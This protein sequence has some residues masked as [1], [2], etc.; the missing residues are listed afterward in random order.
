MKTQNNKL[1]FTK[2]S[3]IELNDQE[4]FDID[5][6]AATITVHVSRDKETHLEIDVTIY[7]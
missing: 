6:A 5:S 2:S 4:M 3:V 7:W 1:D